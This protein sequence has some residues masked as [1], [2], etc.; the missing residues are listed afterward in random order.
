M[1]AR[2][3]PVAATLR[4]AW[5]ARGALR[6]TR[7][8]LARGAVEGIGPAP[9]PDLPPA[10]IRGVEALLRRRRH[11][12]LEGAVV[13]QHWLAAHGIRRDVVIG[14]TAPSDGFAAHA[15]LGDEETPVVGGFH[16]LRRL[17]PP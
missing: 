10:A 3:G 9:P 7:R 14:V 17:A 11:S 15:W 16:E 8:D 2:L 4:A 5:W 13:R 12:C 1:R 6:A